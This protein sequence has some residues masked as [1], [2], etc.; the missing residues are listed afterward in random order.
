MILPLRNS[1]VRLQRCQYII[2]T[3]FISEYLMPPKKEK[4]RQ[5]CS[6][7]TAADLQAAKHFLHLL[8]HMM[9][10]S[11]S[12]V[13]TAAGSPPERA[14]AKKPPVAHCA[15]ERYYTD[16]EEVLSPVPAVFFVAA[17]KPCC[18]CLRHSRYSLLYDHEDSAKPV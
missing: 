14:G 17:G 4:S 8:R 5:S 18:C 15:E 10:F 1:P 13:S 11:S 2:Y 12:M 6:F 9:M 7:R 16:R 3:Y